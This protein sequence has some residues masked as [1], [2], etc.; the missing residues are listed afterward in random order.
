[1][2][3]TRRGWRSLDLARDAAAAWNEILAG[4]AGRTGNSLRKLVADEFIHHGVLPSQVLD[5]LTDQPVAG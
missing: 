1:M 5:R 2:F 3:R 4:R